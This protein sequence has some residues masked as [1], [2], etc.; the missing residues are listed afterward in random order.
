MGLFSKHKGA[1]RS[2]HFFLHLHTLGPFPTAS[3][4]LAVEWQRGSRRGC[5]Q[6]AQP[7]RH[8]GKTWGDYVFEETQHVPCTLYEVRGGDCGAACTVPGT[9][10]LSP[11]ALCGA[12]A[13]A[14]CLALAGPVGAGQRPARRAGL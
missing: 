3:G 7:S 11:A 9:P 2:L 6:A 8:P 12:A 5:S 13:P 14:T 1:G 4:P 10:R